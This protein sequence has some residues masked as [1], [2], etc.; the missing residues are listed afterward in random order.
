MGVTVDIKLA[1]LAVPHPRCMAAGTCQGSCL[2]GVIDSDVHCLLYGPVDVL[3]FPIHY[4]KVV[5][6]GGRACGVGMV[7][8]GEGTLRCYLYLFPK[9]LPVLPIYSIVHP[10]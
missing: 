3:G 5:K 8:D 2:G 9:F 7:M 10:G 6:S 1:Y 4:G